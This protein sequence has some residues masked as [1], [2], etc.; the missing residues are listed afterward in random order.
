MLSRIPN[1]SFNHFCGILVL[2]KFLIFAYRIR[3]PRHGNY[4]HRLPTWAL[5]QCFSPVRIS[6][7]ES[8]ICCNIHQMSA[9]WVWIRTMCPSTVQLNWL[10]VSPV[11]ASVKKCPLSSFQVVEAISYDCGI[12]HLPRIVAVHPRTSHIL[13][14]TDPHNMKVCVALTENKRNVV[15]SVACSSISTAVNKVWIP[16]VVST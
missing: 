14:A 4:I 6:K 15:A 9:C 8:C 16:N 1:I 11:V 2:G 10:R 12:R 7:K 3:F 5:K 13:N